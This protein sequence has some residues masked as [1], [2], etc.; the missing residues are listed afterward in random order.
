M[1]Y[2]S[3]ANLC[4]SIPIYIWRFVSSIDSEKRKEYTLLFNSDNASQM[5]ALLPEFKYVAITMPFKGAILRHLFR[6]YRALYFK[7]LTDKIPCDVFFN[8]VDIDL[9]SYLRSKHK[10]VVVIHDLKDLKTSNWRVRHLCKWIYG[11]SIKG[12][13]AVVAISRFTKCDIIKFYPK[14]DNRKIN[15]IYNSVPDE[16]EKYVTSFVSEGELNEKT[17][18]NFSYHIFKYILFNFY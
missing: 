9:F 15:V 4:Q 2:C 16:N 12:A 17:K 6:F 3:P 18:Y 14:I 1:Y 7:K 10:K 8:A 5:H 11:R 13:D